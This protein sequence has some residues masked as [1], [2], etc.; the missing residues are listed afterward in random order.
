MAPRMDEEGRI[1]GLLMIC[2]RGGDCSACRELVLWTSVSTTK[3]APSLAS[4]IE[5]GKPRVCS[6][7]RR[8]VQYS[9]RV[10]KPAVACAM[11]RCSI[12]GMDAWELWPPRICCVEWA[13]SR[14]S[15]RITD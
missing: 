5:I 10:R 3:C 12:A 1:G 7:G 14:S 13:A 15:E 2:C 11:L 6:L 4:E 8:K 9:E